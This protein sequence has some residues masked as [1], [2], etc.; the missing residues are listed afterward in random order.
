VE[1]G[2]YSVVVIIPGFSFVV[3]ISLWWRIGGGGRV[4]LKIN[5]ISTIF[6]LKRED[7]TVLFLSRIFWATLRVLRSGSDSP[8]LV[9]VGVVMNPPCM[10]ILFPFEQRVYSVVRRCT[11]TVTCLVV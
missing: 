10:L 9:S 1:L 8:L 11:G 5:C 4:P 6:E 7:R 3:A 2:H